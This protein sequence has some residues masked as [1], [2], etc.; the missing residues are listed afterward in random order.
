MNWVT[1]LLGLFLVYG[2]ISASIRLPSLCDTTVF[3]IC[4]C[5]DNETSVVCQLGPKGND[6]DPETSA[7]TKVINFDMAKYQFL[8]EIPH[9]M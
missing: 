8:T 3:P 9:K 7:E 4:T 1:L 5:Y 6:S 2:P